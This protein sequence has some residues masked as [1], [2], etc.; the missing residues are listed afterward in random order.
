MS[1]LQ[2]YTTD[3]REGLWAESI[4]LTTAI[5]EPEFSTTSVFN[6]DIMHATINCNNY[7]VANSSR[8][9]ITFYNSSFIRELT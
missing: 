2:Y 5:Y 3:Y 7:C 1:V 4:I 9:N 6:N 8:K